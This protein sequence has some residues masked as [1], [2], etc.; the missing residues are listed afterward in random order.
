MAEE[1]KKKREDKPNSSRRERPV[2]KEDD[3]M[4]KRLVSV[5]RVTKV[6][7][8]GRTMR[9][10]ALVVIGDGK[11]NVGMGI[12][13]ANEVPNA[14][15]KA[16]VVAKKNMKKVAIVDGTIPHQTT[17]KYS[18]TS[19]LMLPAEEGHGVIAGGAA[20]AVLEVAGVKNIVT[21][22]HGSTNRINVVTA[23]LNGLLSLKTREEIAARRG[24]KPEEI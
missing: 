24:K 21:K 13:K 9:F 20:R 15:D 22:I 6:V 7:K 17:G 19:V 11:G 1:I 2:K 3:G 8:G 18:T 23:T 5:R 14:I 4:D 12:G 16:T 10:S